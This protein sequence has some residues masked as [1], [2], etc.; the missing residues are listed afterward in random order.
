MI[1][2]HI[3]R[4]AMS[5]AFSR[6]QQPWHFVVIPPTRPETSHHPQID[7]TARWSCRA[8]VAIVVCGDPDG[9]KV[10]DLLGRGR[11]PPPPRT[12]SW[13]PG[14]SGLGTVWVG[15]YPEKDPHGRS[16]GSFGIPEHIIPFA[17]DPRRLA[18]LGVRG[19]GPLPSWNQYTGSGLRNSNHSATDGPQEPSSARGPHFCQGQAPFRRC[20]AKRVFP[21][22]R[23]PTLQKGR[24][25]KHGIDS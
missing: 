8:P 23:Q 1:E 7:P 9:K 13:P 21:N 11:E 15:I 16:S 3:L 14:T 12:C 19:P 17:A 18:V 20:P 6:N 25:W 2:Q 4:A 5:R 10:A 22:G 24:S